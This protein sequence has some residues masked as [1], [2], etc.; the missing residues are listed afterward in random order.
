M[1]TASPAEPA[2]D[3]PLDFM[4]RPTPQLRESVAQQRNR[5]SPAE[6]AELLTDIRGVFDKYSAKLR[7]FRA[8]PERAQVLHV[9]LDREMGAAASLEISCRRGC[10]GCCH[11][12]VEVTGDE[13]ELLA[14]LVAGGLPV[15][16][17]RL[18]RQAARERKSPEWSR[19]GH[20]DN[21]CVF[22]GEDGACRV[23]EHRPAICRKH[24]VTSPAAACTETDGA[25]APVRVLLAEILVSAAL[26]L[27]GTT[28]ASLPKLL[29]AAL[30][31]G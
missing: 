27:E 28:F 6:F 22:L 24:L 5:L 2:S 26:S 10:A 1:H 4:A 9:L 11:Y 29:L 31:R 25:V 3:N 16:R 7:E 18:A 15:D 12:E 30:P 17:A 19:H 8:G 21:R 13:A 20:P 23:Y 14:A